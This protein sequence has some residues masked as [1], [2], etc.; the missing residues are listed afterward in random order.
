MTRVIV[1]AIV[2]SLPLSMLSACGNQPHTIN[3]HE[4]SG[5]LRDY[6]SLQASKDTQG[7]TILAWASSKLTRANYNAILLDPLVFYPEPRPS[8]LVSSEELQRILVYSNSLLRHTLAEKF[9]M[10]DRAAPGVLRFRAAISAVAAQPSR[11]RPYE[12]VPIGFIARL[13]ERAATGA[14][15]EALMVI[16]VEGTDSLT[17]ELLGQRVRVGTGERLVKVVE[18]RKVVTLERVMPLLDELAANAFPELDK[19]VEPKSE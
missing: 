7:K 3:Q 6:S 11:L 2:V 14:P 9:R 5:F 13:T 12:Y 15:P 16:E 1:R 18:G 19:Y 4:A 17:G 10:V 8:E